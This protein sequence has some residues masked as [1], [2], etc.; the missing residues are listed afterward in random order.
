MSIDLK[1]VTLAVLI[2]LTGC[3]TG[4]QARGISGGFDEV[5]LSPTMWRISFKGN[6]YT[7][8]DKATNFVLLRS[9]D[10]TIKNGFKS[11]IIIDA[12]SDIEYSTYN[13][14][15]AGTS[16]LMTRP[17]SSN[18]ILM[19]SDTDD[20]KGVVYDAQF[21]CASLGPKYEVQCGQF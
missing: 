5:R 21:L 7:D 16:Q 12:N 6:A 11:F 18:T 20:F 19:L 3:A 15:A 10:L 1:F 14:V 2:T 8:G 13:N 9:A 17:S 4:Y